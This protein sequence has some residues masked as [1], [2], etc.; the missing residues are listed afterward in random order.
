MKKNNN[1][2]YFL[3]L[4][5]LTALAYSFYINR[6]GFYTSDNINNATTSLNDLLTGNLEQ[7]KTII[8]D[9]SN[10][11][12]KL[13]ISG[14]INTLN[15][16][17]TPD[18]KIN[19]PELYSANSYLKNELNNLAILQKN[20]NNINKKIDSLFE[21]TKIEIT[22][23]NTQV[24]ETYGLTEALNKLSLDIKKITTS[25]SQIPS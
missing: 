25:L 12:Y 15:E 2:L 5:I 24:N 23:M 6:E 3:L 17:Y 19:T 21:G 13:S 8:S 20:I 22:D 1:F 16:E 11:K 14:V 4:I 10:Q 7:L 9:L 18:S